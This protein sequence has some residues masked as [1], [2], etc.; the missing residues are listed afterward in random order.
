V[1]YVSD[2]I[3]MSDLQKI[4]GILGVLLLGASAVLVADKRRTLAA[5]ERA[6]AEQPVEELADHLKEAWAQYHTP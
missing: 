4:C 5:R 1:I 3:K 2:G 6:A